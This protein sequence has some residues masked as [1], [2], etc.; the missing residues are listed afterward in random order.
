[1]SKITESSKFA[2]PADVLR[3]SA[4]LRAMEVL[5]ASGAQFSITLPDGQ[6]FRHPEHSAREKRRQNPENRGT[7]NE[8]IKPHVRN[9]LKGDASMFMV[10]FPKRRQGLALDSFQSILCGYLSVICK[11][12]YNTAIDTKENGVLVCLRDSEA[13]TG[14][15]NAMIERGEFDDSDAF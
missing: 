10:P 8:D 7:L 1:M 13:V 9:S 11:G 15:K 6:E 14:A 3:K 5:K 2:N 12:R 4:C